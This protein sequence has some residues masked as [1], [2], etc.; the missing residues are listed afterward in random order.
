MIGILTSEQEACIA[1]S[2]KQLI[3]HCSISR[4]KASRVFTV[5][6]NSPG[7]AAQQISIRVASFTLSTSNCRM[8]TE[9]EFNQEQD[10]LIS[11]LYTV[12]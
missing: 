8:N 1:K 2:L 11:A 4:P 12:A 3:T 7:L 6:S 10:M 5:D 9:R